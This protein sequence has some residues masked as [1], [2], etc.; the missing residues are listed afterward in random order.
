MWIDNSVVDY[1]N[2][3]SGMPNSDSCVAISSDT[4]LWTTTSCSR[5]RS[6]I[7]KLA[8]GRPHLMHLSAQMTSSVK[9]FIPIFQSLHRQKHHH[10]L[11][12]YFPE[13]MCLNQ[14]SMTKILT[15]L[16]C[17]YSQSHN[18]TLSGICRSY[19]GCNIGCDRRGR[20]WWLL[21]LPKEDTHASVG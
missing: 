3:K 4:G 13:D 11:V 16:F 6:Y 19:R 12:S 20:T 17:P 18:G 7:C 5:Y 1:T 9:A 8:K 15:L 10:L 21:L 2:W 14:T